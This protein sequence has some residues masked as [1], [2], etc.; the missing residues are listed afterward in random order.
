MAQRREARKPACR[1]TGPHGIIGRA[2][3]RSTSTRILLAVPTRLYSEAIQAALSPVAG[4]EVV[5]RARTTA[6]IT[7]SVERSSPDIL[8]MD[9]T[10]ELILRL[11]LAATLM[12]TH[13]GLRV[14]G[15][16]PVLRARHAELVLRVHLAG[17]LHP[18]A[19]ADEFILAIAEVSAGRTY[20]SR[21]YAD[22]L[23]KRFAGRE[24]ATD[25]RTRESLSEREAE[26]LHLV[27]RGFTSREVGERLFI[28]P[29]T[30]ENHLAGLYRKLRLNDGHQLSCA[31]YQDE[32]AVPPYG[33]D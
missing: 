15:M 31:V 11:E 25:R 24:P 23:R 29:R 21:G 3:S 12:R 17:L 27:A 22:D 7:G 8:L 32:E 6:E 26:V 5:G 13:P 19:E 10:A 30:V 16:L 28:S 18:N 4:L 33:E 9:L 1:S 20:L 2:R 14:I